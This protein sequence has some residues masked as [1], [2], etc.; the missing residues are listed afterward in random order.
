EREFYLIPRDTYS[1]IPA[2]RTA[3]QVP[4]GEWREL[5][6]DGVVFG[7]VQKTGENVRVQVRLFNV[8]S[9]Q[10]VFAKEYNGRAQNPRLY[11]HTMSDEIHQQQRALRGVARTK[12]TFSS[13]RNREKITG[14]VEN[15]DVKEIYISDYD[16]VGQR[17]I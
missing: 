14:T 5:G 1:T 11:A 17:R 16:G 8:R 6:A 2:A 12:L 3:E 4:F 9:R 10:S 7:T 15:R 13:D